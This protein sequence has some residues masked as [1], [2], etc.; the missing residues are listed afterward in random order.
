VA[1]KVASNLSLVAVTIPWQAECSS[2][3]SISSST[4][5]SSSTRRLAEIPISRKAELQCSAHTV[6]GGSRQVRVVAE[7]PHQVEWKITPE[8]TGTSANLIRC[9]SVGLGCSMQYSM[10]RR[11]VVSDREIHAYQL[12]GI[13]GS[14]TC[15]RD[16]YKESSWVSSS[17]TDGQHYS[18]DVCQQLWGNNIPTTHR[19]GQVSMDVS[20]GEADK[21]YSPT[22]TMNAELN[23]S[24]R[25]QGNAGP[26]RLDVEPS[27]VS[28]DTTVWSTRGQPLHLGCPISFHAT[29]AGSRTLWQRQ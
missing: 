22:Y 7:M 17:N 21:N 13:I 23:C 4:V 19:A 3:G 26:V 5:L 27:D 16:L 15:C 6:L 28:S 2:P 18:S 14:H 20:S 12:P 10:Y 25:V 8:V 11:P 9:I 1:A 24:C 29:S